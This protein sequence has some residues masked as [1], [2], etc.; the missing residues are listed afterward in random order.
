MVSPSKVKAGNQCPNGVVM[1]ET[2]ISF[3]DGLVGGI[4]FSLYTPM[5]ITVT[6]AASGTASADVGS[7]ITIPDNSTDQQIKEAFTKASA[8]PLLQKNLFL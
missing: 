6:C 1:V 3:L 5:H 2:K 4:T 7:E 8:E